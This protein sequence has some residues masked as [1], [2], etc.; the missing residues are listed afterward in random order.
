MKETGGGGWRGGERR[1]YDGYWHDAVS[2]G[3][4]E[5]EKDGSEEGGK[6]HDVNK[7]GGEGGDRIEGK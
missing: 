1:R 5:M 6:D 2:R 7:T 4:E 3:T